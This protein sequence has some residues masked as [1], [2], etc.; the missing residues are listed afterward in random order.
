MSNTV[1][2]AI[3]AY[4]YQRFG[5]FEGEVSTI[6]KTTTVGDKDTFLARSSLRFPQNS[7][8]PA[9]EIVLLPGMKAKA[10][11]QTRKLSIFQLVYEKLFSNE[12]Y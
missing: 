11:I 2:I 7:R 1:K 10:Y 5:H 4:P 3:E 6:D 12:S 8:T 9:N